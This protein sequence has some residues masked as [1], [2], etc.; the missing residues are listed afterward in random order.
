MLRWG[1]VYSFQDREVEGERKE[2]GERGREGEE[3][4]NREAIMAG[5][6]QGQLQPSLVIKVRVPRPPNHPFGPTPGVNHLVWPRPIGKTTPIPALGPPL[7]PSRSFP[8]KTLCS[9]PPPGP[10]LVHIV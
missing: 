2:D 9:D 5:Q 8:R 4:S 1:C 3:N 10:F 6:R 7:C